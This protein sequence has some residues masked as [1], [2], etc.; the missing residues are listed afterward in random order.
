MLIYN[1]LDRSRK[2]PL[3]LQKMSGQNG[4]KPSEKLTEV[5]L[6]YRIM[7]KN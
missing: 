6:L 2:I 5:C 7:G 3:G 4:M 1:F